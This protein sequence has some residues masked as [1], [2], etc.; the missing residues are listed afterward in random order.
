MPVWPEYTIQM[1]VWLR[2]N[3]LKAMS[4]FP[5]GNAAWAT[6]AGS[7]TQAMVTSADR[8]VRTSRA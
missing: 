3:L 7:T 6:G 1:S 4:P 2:V 8:I 5:P